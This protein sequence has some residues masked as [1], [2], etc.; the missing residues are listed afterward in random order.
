VIGTGLARLVTDPDE[1]SRYSAAASSWI[2]G[3]MEQV[4]LIE[5]EIVTG[6]RLVGWCG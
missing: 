6:R 4:V 3:P 1:V 5:P 2:A